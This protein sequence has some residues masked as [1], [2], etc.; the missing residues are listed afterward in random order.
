MLEYSSPGGGSHTSTRSHV[1]DGATRRWRSPQ[2]PNSTIPF[3]PD[4]NSAYSSRVQSPYYTRLLPDWD[5]RKVIPK[6]ID[7][8]I[9]RLRKVVPSNARLSMK[10][11]NK[12]PE[13]CKL[14]FSGSPK[15]NWAHIID[16]LEA[17]IFE[18]HEFFPKQCYFA[19]RAILK[20]DA[21]TKLEHLE[22]NLEAPHSWKSCIPPW[23]KPSGQDWEAIACSK[24]FTSFSYGLRCAIMVVYFHQKFQK[25]TSR[26][27]WRTLVDA[28]QLPQ[29]PIQKWLQRVR[30]D[31]L[32]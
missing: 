30:S 5:S 17:G 3:S 27:A 32:V 20:D 19:F 15:E 10:E 2:A 14:R 21:L 7:S 28:T 9:Q 11:V 13:N 26:D 22:E 24:P 12:V 16:F 1:S 29:E 4:F 25:G 23:F 31:R 8:F 18:K 6:P